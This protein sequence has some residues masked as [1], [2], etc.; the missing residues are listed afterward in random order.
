MS[1]DQQQ[2]TD[3]QEPDSDIDDI[4]TEHCRAQESGEVFEGEHPDSQ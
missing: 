1:T 2:S 3:E 4:G